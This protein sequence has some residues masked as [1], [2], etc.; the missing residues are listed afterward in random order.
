MQNIY[1]IELFWI[2]FFLSTTIFIREL[3]VLE[4]IGSDHFPICCF[5]CIHP[6]NSSQEKQVEKIT[7][8][9][10]IETA[11]FIEKGKKEERKKVTIE[12]IK[13][14]LLLTS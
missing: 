14:S 7:K 12:K 3:N 4:Y 5:F 1:S 9:E 6:K 2:Y 10:K 11:L 8:E 13:K